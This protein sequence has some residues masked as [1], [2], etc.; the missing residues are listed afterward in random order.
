MKFKHSIQRRVFLAFGGFTFM[1]ALLY[2]GLSILTAFV[3]EDEILEKVLA[4]EA[5]FI[6]GQF[7]EKRK[8]VESRV[9]Y[10]TLYLIP[11]DAPKEVTESYKNNPKITEVFTENKKHYHI[12]H[13]YLGDKY[14]PLLVADV[15]NLLTVS[16]ISNNVL[17]LF[18][19]LLFFTLIVAMWFVYRLVQHTT[20]PIVRLSRDVRHQQETL[21]PLPLAAYQKNDEIGFLAN[22]IESTITRLKNTVLRE[23]NFNRDVSHELRTPITIM[24]NT[25]AL[26]KKIELTQKDIQE[27]TTSVNTMSVIVETLLALAREE[28]MQ[29]EALLLRAHLEECVL[30]LH[31]LLEK[32]DFRVS[33]EVAENYKIQANSQLLTLLITNLIEN[34]HKHALENKLVIRLDTTTEN[35]P[36]LVFE[37]TTNIKVNNNIIEPNIKRPHSNGIGQGLFLANRILEALKWRYKVDSSNTTYRF[38]VIMNKT[39][40]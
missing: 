40:N 15:T 14:N 1:L 13:L 12:Q 29:V 2:S 26:S 34:A 8:I 4:Q 35:T 25:L 38:I 3:V 31:P 33:L 18:S 30:N 5:R 7:Q 6:E 27:L 11:E 10:M 22:V 37:N 36:L 28:S 17:L 24:R 23:S 19:L 9:D 39:N 16:N 21:E 32:S 20:K